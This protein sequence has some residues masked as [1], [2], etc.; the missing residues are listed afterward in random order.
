MLL[1]PTFSKLN[2]SQVARA[3]WAPILEEIASP[4]HGIEHDAATNID[5]GGVVVFRPID[6]GTSSGGRGMLPRAAEQEAAA[7]TLCEPAAVAGPG[8]RRASRGGQARAG[9]QPAA[10]QREPAPIRS[11]Q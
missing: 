8:A 1:F 7:V 6:G 10:G 9:D 5:G 11:G 3:W 2:T 4:P